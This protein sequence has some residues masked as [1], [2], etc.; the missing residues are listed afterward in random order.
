MMEH[1]LLR[2]YNVCAIAHTEC[3]QRPRSTPVAIFRDGNK[4][5]YIEDGALKIIKQHH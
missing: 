2:V 5:F 4:L 1:H 3:L